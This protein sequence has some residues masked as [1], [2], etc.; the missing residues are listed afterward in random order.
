MSAQEIV[1]AIEV[2]T[3]EK[4]EVLIIRL[5]ADFGEYEEN[6]VKLQQHLNDGP[7]KDRYFVFIGDV[8]FAKVKA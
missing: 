1:K 8:E 6:L 4:D 5:D 3:V 2:L 7:L